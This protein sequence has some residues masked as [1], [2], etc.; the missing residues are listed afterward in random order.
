MGSLRDRGR[1]K[2][3]EEQSAPRLTRTVSTPHP[4]GRTWWSRARERTGRSFSSSRFVRFDLPKDR[5]VGVSG[6]YSPWGPTH[7]P[8]PRLF[9]GHLGRPASPP[10][11]ALPLS[12]PRKCRSSSLG[13]TKISWRSVELARTRCESA[14]A[15]DARTEDGRAGGHS[16]R[17]DEPGR[18]RKEQGRGLLHEPRRTR[19]E[20]R[21]SQQRVS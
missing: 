21:T 16:E 11:C 13:Q 10:G 4:T 3:E 12:A 9:R 2:G 7:S 14:R 6:E 1:E 20:R 18:R 5:D 8:L 17:R 15:H 19:R